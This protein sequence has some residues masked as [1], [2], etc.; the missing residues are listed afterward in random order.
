MEAAANT[1]HS[2]GW[3]GSDP[4]LKQS[5]KPIAFIVSLSIRNFCNTDTEALC[6]VWNAHYADHGFACSI[7]PL[8][9]ELC[10]LA[11]PYFDPQELL[12][13]ASGDEIMGFAHLSHLSDGAMNESTTQRTAISALCVLP[14]VHEA[15]VAAEL[16]QKCDQLS[17]QLGAQQC[18]FKPMLPDVPFYLGLGPG[19]SMI[20][21]TSAEHRTCRWISEAGYRPL[22]PTTQWEL[23]VDSFQPPVD[24]IQVQIRRSAYVNRQVDEPLLPWWQACALGHTEPA[25]FHLIHRTQ[26]RVLQDVLYWGITP[27]LQSVPDSIAWLWP[28]TLKQLASPSSIPESSAADHLL[29]L[30]AESLNQL[31]DESIDLVR[32]VSPADNL[33]VNQILKRVGFKSSQNG[34]VFAKQ[35]A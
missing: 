31:K 3:R 28:L 35:F 7:D 4:F 25:A 16:L 22:T 32:S 12:I 14:H 5:L 27:E 10:C 18:Q 13:A 33:Q 2:T 15:A 23:A 17:L 6:R 9:L 21:A 11:K 24:R 26:L 29:F 8:R 34:V 30:I 19:D 1:P 20:G